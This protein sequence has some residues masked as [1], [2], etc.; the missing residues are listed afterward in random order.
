MK[1]EKQE[2]EAFVLV[3]EG[4]IAGEVFVDGRDAWTGLGSE[5]VA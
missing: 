3:H 4:L 2:G 5:E 1:L